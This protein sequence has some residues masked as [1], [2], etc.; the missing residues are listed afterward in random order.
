M[1]TIWKFPV[2][3]G[4]NTIDLPAVFKVLTVQLQDEE[5]VMWVVLNTDEPPE[6]VT[7]HVLPTGGEVPDVPLDYV[8]T[9]QFTNG[10]VFHVFRELST[11]ESLMKIRL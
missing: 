6:P 2:E 4:T 1:R 5:P 8:D 11:L 3:A 7:F 9:F 10:L